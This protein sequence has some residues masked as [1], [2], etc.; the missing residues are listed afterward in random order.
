MKTT[1]RT[2]R[3]LVVLSVACLTVP[4]VATGCSSSKSGAES[5]A[6]TSQDLYGLGTAATKWTNGVVPVCF[7]NLNANSTDS[8]LQNQLQTILANSWSAA[9]NITFTGF[10]D[11]PSSGNFV[12]VVF[13]TG[14]QGGDANVGQGRDTV[15]LSSDGTNTTAGLAEFTH[16]AIHEFG[17]VLGFEHEMQRP[18]N[19]PG[20]VAQQCPP[21][22]G[23]PLAWA[24]NPVP[25]GIN[26]TPNY[27]P[28]SIMNYCSPGGSATTLSV[29]DIIGASGPQ[30]YGPPATG[31]VFA[32]TS[33]GCVA[34]S[35][36]ESET[37]TVPAACPTTG[38]WVLQQL[39]GSNYTSVSASSPTSF[40][41]GTQAG[42]AATSGPPIGSVQTSRVCDTYGNCS[43]P[44]QVTISDCNP[45]DGLALDAN[46][47]PLQVVAGGAESGANVIMSG[48]WTAHDGG[49]NATGQVLSQPN[50]GLIVTLGAGFTVN[51]AGAVPIKVSAPPLATPGPYQ[52]TIS[53]KDAYTQTTLTATIPIQVL[54]CVPQSAST[55]CQPSGALCGTYSAGCGVTVNCGSCAS[56][57]VCSNG[58]CCAAGYFYNTALN[59][60]EPV[61][62]PSGT[63]Y[64][65]IAGGC[66]TPAVCTK[67][68]GGGGGTCKPGTC[69]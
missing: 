38:S 10:G 14:T 17:H 59:T 12:T 40:V 1:L 66:V 37:F 42:G 35:Q 45:S 18:D 46:D 19:W 54:A 43:A 28:A 32:N 11:C 62:C 60:C 2:T 6:Q 58:V 31:C 48:P 69:S 29:G 67:L 41:F 61:S 7:Q 51:G 21:G 49:L 55:V 65:A 39:A 30:A 4:A 52:A 34:G 5:I 22:S 16:I 8:A 23:N 53:V 50:G 64:C 13:L 57:N 33:T 3:T 27:D 68:E 26:L 63:E 9:A 24:Y 56:G 47:S 20:G 15:N 36:G 25:G 44:F